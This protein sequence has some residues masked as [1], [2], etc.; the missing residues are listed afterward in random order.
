MNCCWS[1]SHTDMTSYHPIERKKSD[2][3]PF[4]ELNHCSSVSRLLRKKQYV[5]EYQQGEKEDVVILPFS[6]H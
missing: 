2:V 5:F 6:H 3:A 1:S 4:V